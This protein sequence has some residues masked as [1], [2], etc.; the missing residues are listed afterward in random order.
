MSRNSQELALF[1]PSHHET[2]TGSGPHA[3]CPIGG[4]RGDSSAYF[5]QE[6]LSLLTY[7][8]RS[9][10][11]LLFGGFAAFLIRNLL[12]GIQAE[13]GGDLIIGLH[14][15]VT[16]VLGGTALLLMRHRGLSLVQLRTLETVVFGLPAAFFVWMQ[17][18]RICYC[19][20]TRAVELAAAFP[21]ATI[22]PWILLIQVYGLFIP[23]TWKRATTVIVLMSIVPLAGAIAAANHSPLVAA[24]LRNGGFSLMVL[25]IAI[26]SVVAVYG[27]H[28]LGRLRRE[29]FDAQNVGAYTLCE[30]LGSGGM[31]D[32]YLAEH[33]LLKRRCAIKLIK[34]EKADDPNAL[35][36]FESEVR[37]AAQLTHPNTIEI[38]DYGH[39]RDGV[40]YYAMEYLPG[41]NLQEI[42]ERFGPLPPERVVHLLRQVCSA[43]KEA[44]A[45]G[46]IHRDIKPGNIFAAERGGLYDVAKLL[47]FGLV[48]SLQVDS[49]PNSIKL[50]LDGAVVG[51]PLFAAPETTVDG[52]PGPA[53]DIYSLGATAYFLLTGQAVFPGN[54]PLKV[55]FAHA[56]EIPQPISELVPQL[57]RELAEIIM[58]CLEKDPNDRFADV[59]ELEAALNNCREVPEWS[60]QAARDW[61]SDSSINRSPA[62][63]SGSKMNAST[64]QETEVT[65][66]MQVEH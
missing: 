2:A 43:L 49:D 29:V 21:S 51:S 50:T 37:A 38:F 64:R 59:G 62:K 20:G 15:I 33:R 45:A 25:W 40:F 12:V 63:Q 61:W 26:S 8:L 66:I 58:K 36:R 4:L 1:S 3:F 27:T 57:P 9:A 31:G 60:Q 7:R 5:K 19:D 10:A 23:N 54:N 16:V 52:E 28:R 46:L 30:K 24:E 55:I 44:H 18:C 47:D 34:S 11:W 13:P 56:N 14:A 65:A 6:V 17:F 39:T 35:A 48:K 41:L 32:V 53:S 22:I 42:V